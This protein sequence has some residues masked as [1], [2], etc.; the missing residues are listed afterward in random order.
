MPTDLGHAV[1]VPLATL[2]TPL[3]PLDRLSAELGGPRLW[4]KRDDC[5][6]LAGGGNKV[7][8]LEFLLADAVAAEADMVV[9]GG[10]VQSNHARLAAAACAHAGLPCELWLNRR[11]A[12]RPPHYEQ[13]G[14]LMLDRLLGAR[15]HFLPGDADVD[16]VVERRAA[17]L[18]RD[19]ARPYAMPAGGSNVVGSRGYV[20]C[21]DE[22]LEQAGEAGVDIDAIVVAVGSGGTLAG[23]SVGLAAAGWRGRLIGVAVSTAAPLVRRRVLD[24]AAATAAAIG[25]PGSVLDVEIDDRQIGPGY[26]VPTPDCIDA[27]RRLARSHALLLDPAYTGKAM[28]AL[29]ARVREGGLADGDD[30]V[31][32]H[33]GGWP[34]LSSYWEDL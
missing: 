18:R 5:T 11:V 8:K 23:L 12:D 25:R 28:A 22:L 15:V 2:P 34:A 17:E 13:L 16:V 20:A 32:L 27:V 9:T 10:A 33:T 31:F 29:L 6:G 30:V 24:L 1:R 3:E 21:A 19:G 14:N 7:R 26:G 4:V